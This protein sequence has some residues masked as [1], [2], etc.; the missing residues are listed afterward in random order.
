[1]IRA[2]LYITFCLMAV[3][4]G[5]T[6]IDTAQRTSDAVNGQR[7]EM[8]AQANEVVPSSCRMPQ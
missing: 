1:M 4:T 8:C 6:V 2:V 7:A 3:K 5:A